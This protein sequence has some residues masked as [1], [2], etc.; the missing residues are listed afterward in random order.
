MFRDYSLWLVVVIVTPCLTYAGDLMDAMRKYEGRWVGNF[1]LHSAATGYTETFPVEQQYWMAENKLHGVAVT[2]RNTGMESARSVT[3][4]VDDKLVTEITTGTETQ[5][6]LGVLHEQGVLWLPEEMQRANDHQ[7]KEMIL[8]EDGELRLKT[9]GFD[10][11]IYQE[12]LAHIIYRG[13]L[14]FKK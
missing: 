2:D 6:Y 11:Y 13:N 4:I 3:F 9:E 8:V 12:G 5:R 1:T 7:L 14:V 10:T